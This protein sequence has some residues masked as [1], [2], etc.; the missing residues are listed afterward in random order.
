M[1][2]EKASMMLKINMLTFGIQR[3][4]G[5]DDAFNSKLFFQVIVLP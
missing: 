5:R 4:A 1:N 2:L 3:F